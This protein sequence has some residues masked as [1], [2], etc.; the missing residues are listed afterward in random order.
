MTR[1][2]AML[3]SS[4]EHLVLLTCGYATLLVRPALAECTIKVVTG[5][6]TERE[7]GRFYFILFYFILFYLGWGGGVGLLVVAWVQ[8]IS[9]PCAGGAI[10]MVTRGPIFPASSHLCGRLRGEQEL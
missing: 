10:A 5:A 3:C 8:G 2:G 1:A 4:V 6:K 7:G 9:L